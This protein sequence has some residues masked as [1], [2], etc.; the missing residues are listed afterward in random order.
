M[1]EAKHTKGP[2]EVDSVPLELGSGEF[3]TV[4]T[5]GDGPH[6]AFVFSDME[7]D[8][9]LIA[10]APDLLAACQ[11]LLKEYEPGCIGEHD[12]VRRAKAAIAKAE[13]K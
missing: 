5:V 7:A 12:V 10:A 4:Q 13:G 6:I 8:A 2:W 3:L 11:A 9:H 1:I